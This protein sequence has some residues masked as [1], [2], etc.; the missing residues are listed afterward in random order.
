VEVSPFPLPHV[1]PLVRA[2]DYRDA[3]MHGYPFPIS[4]DQNG[5]YLK[6]NPKSE[7]YA[8]FADLM[9]EPLLAFCESSHNAVVDVIA[10]GRQCFEI[11]VF[12]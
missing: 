12:S 5:L 3:I 4:G 6:V 2:L 8:Y 11:D 1:Y 7:G 9:E 10:K